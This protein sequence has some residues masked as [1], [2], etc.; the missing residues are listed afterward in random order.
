[1]TVAD[2]ERP[3][4]QEV[5]ER[6]WLTEFLRTENGLTITEYAIAAGLI[7]AAIA[8]SFAVLGATV[9]AILLAVIAF[10]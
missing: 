1:M 7:A 5:P 10:L 4:N 8:A 6:K 3:I 9:D 2:P